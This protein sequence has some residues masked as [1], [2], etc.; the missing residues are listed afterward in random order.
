M[1][2]NNLQVYAIDSQESTRILSSRSRS[3]RTLRA[4]VRFVENRLSVTLEQVIRLY[5]FW[6]A[7]A[8]LAPLT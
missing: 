6:A 3:D 8:N 7:I 4:F 1:T 2:P 5:G